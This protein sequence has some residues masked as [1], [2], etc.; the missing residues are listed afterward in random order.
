MP[1][2]GEDFLLRFTHSLTFLALGFPF[3]VHGLGFPF[4]VQ[5]FPHLLGFTVS[6]SGLRFP[7]RAVRV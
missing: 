4:R 7:V 3:R 2:R 6:F 5:A 1:F